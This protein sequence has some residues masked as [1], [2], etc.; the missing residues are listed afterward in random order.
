MP[1]WTIFRHLPCPPQLAR[2]GAACQGS[3]ASVL[4]SKAQFRVPSPCRRRHTRRACLGIA[5]AGSAG[6]HQAIRNVA[7]SLKVIRSC[8]SW[9]TR[10]SC[11]TPAGAFC[12]EGRPWVRV[13]TQ[14]QKSHQDAQEGRL[15]GSCCQ[16]R[17]RPD[18]ASG[19]A[20]PGDCSAPKQGHQGRDGHVLLQTGGMETGWSSGMLRQEE[21]SKPVERT[22][23]C[24]TWRLFIR[25]MHQ[26]S[27]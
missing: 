18:P 8:V 20:R 13:G 4:G 16:G 24:I 1:V 5:N 7:W 2:C 6:L 12:H 19:K 10:I 27:A 22:I 15:E 14:Q 11:R 9:H 3:H 21:G 25:M 23:K 26:A 17:P